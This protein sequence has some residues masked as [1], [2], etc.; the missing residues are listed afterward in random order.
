MSKLKVDDELMELQILD[1]ISNAA[2][3]SDHTFDEFFA[4][5]E[6]VLVVFDASD[7]NSQ[8]GSGRTSE[9]AGEG[10][11]AKA[12][13]TQTLTSGP[14][15]LPATSG[16]ERGR[17]CAAVGRHHRALPEPLPVLGRQQN[18]LGGVVRGARS[19]PLRQRVAAVS[20]HPN[21][22]RP[23]CVSGARAPAA[24][25]TADVPF[26]HGWRGPIRDERPNGPR[27]DH[28]DPERLAVSARP[29]PR[30]PRRLPC[31]CGTLT[32]QCPAVVP[33]FKKTIGRRLPRGP[34]APAPLP[35]EGA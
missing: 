3:W 34:I 21:G 15:P 17:R 20:A 31:V 12:P 4:Y 32:K 16:R 10:G 30:A 7:P 27:S 22:P 26:R 18:R 6:G 24:T 23:C 33:G 35:S 5:I 29:S 14:R 11:E 13:Q 19:C 28:H 8:E 1:T 9:W 2:L 25:R